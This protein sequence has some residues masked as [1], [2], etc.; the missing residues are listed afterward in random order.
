MNKDA[1]STVSAILML[2]DLRQSAKLAPGASA[3]AGGTLRTR[4]PTGHVGGQ[5]EHSDADASGVDGVPGGGCSA[6][7]VTEPFHVKH[8]RITEFYAYMLPRGAVSRE[9][10]SDVSPG[11]SSP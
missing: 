5:F 7:T 8:T 10:W 1:P 11:I 3:A 6:G 4:V 2:L 9:T